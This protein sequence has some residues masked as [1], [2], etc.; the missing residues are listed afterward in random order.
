MK[1]RIISAFLALFLS[2]SLSSCSILLDVSE[3]TGVGTSSS[4]EFSSLSGSA[5]NDDSS[6]SG[7]KESSSGANSSGSGASSNDGSSIGGSTGDI[8]YDELSIHFLQLGNRVSGDCTLIKVGDVEVLIDAGSTKGSATT[9]V[10]YIQQYCT[11]NVLEYVIATHAHED[12]IAAFAGSDNNGIFANFECETIIDF[13][14]TAVTSQ[15][16]QK[17]VALRDAEVAQGAKHYTALECWN[18]ENG[19]Q[20]SYELGKGVTLNILYQ[21]YYET[22]T[23]TEN[24]YSVCTLISQE[25]NH[26]LFTGDLEESGEKSLVASNDLPECVLYKAG[27]HGSNTSSSEELLKVIQPEIVVFC[28]CCGDK[29]G[30]PHQETIDKVSVY[31]DKVYV[32]LITSGSTYALLNGNIVVTSNTDGVRVNCSNNNTLFK[33]TEWFKANR[34]WR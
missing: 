17:Y 8:L 27:H 33:D 26:F 18:N 21:K 29:H 30:F 11:D 34:V 12:H 6:S 13:A 10:P 3:S 15:I 25:D 4:S 23:S 2:V 28:C 16:Y 20:R 22:K 19:A 7:G 31:T 24:N 32:P 1:K 5:S 9:I 14:Q